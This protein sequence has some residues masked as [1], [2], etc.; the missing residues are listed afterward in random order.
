MQ[1]KQITEHLIYHRKVSNYE[2]MKTTTEDNWINQNFVPLLST[3]QMGLSGSLKLTSKLSHFKSKWTI[4][5]KCKYSMPKAASIAIISLFRRSS[6]LQEGFW[7]SKKL[8]RGW[9]GWKMYESTHLSFLISTFLNDPFTI[10]SV[11]VANV[12]PGPSGTTP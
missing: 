5:F 9:K 12:P 2:W 7:G 3:L 4:F 1:E 8:F 6:T 11:M 10:Y